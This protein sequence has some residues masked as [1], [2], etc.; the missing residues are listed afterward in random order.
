M[1]HPD[2]IGTGDRDK[3]DIIT[4]AYRVLSDPQRRKEYD[5]DYKAASHQQW[6]SLSKSLPSDEAETDRKI[7]QGILGILYIA[8]RHDA[9]GPGVGIVHLER[10]LGCPEKYLEFHIW[11]LKEKGWIQRLETGGFA[12]TA[13][14]VDAVI[15]KDLMLR[16]DRLL[17]EANDISNYEESIDSD[18]AGRVSG[19]LAGHNRK[20]ATR[21][22]NCFT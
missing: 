20:A 19:D 1:Y 10:Q 6:E 12:I 2:N 21:L 5:A 11:Y 22:E 4:K 3:F 17:P 15:E 8:R 9:Q 16:K 18:G 7:Y 13:G 14:G